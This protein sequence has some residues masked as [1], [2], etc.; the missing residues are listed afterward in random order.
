MGDGVGDG[1]GR[2]TAAMK[3]PNASGELPASIVAM[4]VLVDVSITEAVLLP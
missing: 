4:T 2:G 1:D 3:L